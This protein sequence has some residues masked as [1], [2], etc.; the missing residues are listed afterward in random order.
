MENIKPTIKICMRVGESVII[1]IPR[2]ELHN[3]V[4]V[5]RIKNIFLSTYKLT[6]DSVQICLD[7]VICICRFL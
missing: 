3:D 5:L 7:R 2:I 4:N 1:N 6:N